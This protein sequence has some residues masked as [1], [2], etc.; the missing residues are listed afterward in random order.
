[1]NEPVVFAPI[2]Q[3]RVWGGRGFAD[4]YGRE[5][6]AGPVG[7]AWQLVDRSEAQSVVV[8]GAYDGRSLADLW[9]DERALF[10]H[11]A[12]DLTGPF[13]L[14]VKLL[15]ARDTL[16][17]QVHPPT[18]LAASLGGEPK[19]E[20]WY[21]VRAEPGA[22]VL[23]GLREGVTADRF[24]EVQRDGGDLSRLLHRHEVQVGDCLLV[25][26][27]RVHALGA[28]CLVVEVQQNS[29][30]TYR[31]Y[32]FDRPGVDG[33]P[34]QLHVEQSLLCIDFSDVEPELVPRGDRL[35]AGTDHFRLE[36]SRAVET[37]AEC[38]FVCV[39]SGRARAGEATFGPGEFFLL[40]PGGTA[41]GDLLVT[42]LPGPEQGTLVG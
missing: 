15:D 37:G 25:P 17:V 16:S 41:T 12:H 18:H 31:V 14:L 23:A 20:A 33:Q 5:L 36:T 30:T 1:M 22:H 7:E 24:A 9:A 34:R 21:V 26:S 2:Y 40:P 28:G 13:P 3:E 38:A 10:G 8:G 19:T 42:W 35:V 39:L 27:G 6:P 32:D 29:D 4:L 11:R